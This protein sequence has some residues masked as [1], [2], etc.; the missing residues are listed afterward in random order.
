MKNIV[1]VVAAVIK[2]DDLILC[3]QR[4]NSKQFSGYW[5]FPGGKVEKDETKEEAL[6]REIKE[7]LNVKIKV[8]HLISIID[9]EY[10]DFILKMYVYDCVLLEENIILLEHQAMKWLRKEN[11][12]TLNW[13]P[14]DFALIEILKK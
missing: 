1:E 10:V 13:L 3:T 11:L 5:E 14:S 6:I 12:D 8:N 4:P 2:K 7:E 9:Y